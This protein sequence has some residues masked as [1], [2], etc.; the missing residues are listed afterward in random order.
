MRD[1]LSLASRNAALTDAG[2][3][4]GRAALRPWSERGKGCGEHLQPS[5]FPEPRDHPPPG[6]PAM[7]KMSVELEAQ[8]A[9]RSFQEAG[10]GE[11][12]KTYSLM[13]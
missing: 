12:N 2:S 13:L 7:K 3:C 6:V 10:G 4:D 11:N 8:K 1:R 5:V 9:C